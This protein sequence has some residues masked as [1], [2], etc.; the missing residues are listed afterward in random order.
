MQLKALIVATLC[1]FAVMAVGAGPA[2]AGEVKGPPTNDD[3][4]AM[5]GNANSICGFSGLNDTYSGDPDVP[6]VDGFTRT[7]SWGQVDKE[8]KEFLT[9]IGENP[10][11]ACNG[12]DNPMK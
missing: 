7:Q 8:G 2:F 5:R 3:E 12:H 4:T 9:S 10:G 11:E 6:D 1:A